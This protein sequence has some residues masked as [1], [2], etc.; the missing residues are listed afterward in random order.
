MPSVSAKNRQS[1]FPFSSTRATCSYH[2]GSRKSLSLSGWRHMPWWW[3]VGPVLRKATR[4]IF[5][6]ALIDLGVCQRNALGTDDEVDLDRAAEGQTRDADGGARRQAAGREVARVFRVH[7]R[8]VAEVH[9]VHAHHHRAA[10]ARARAGE[11][12]LE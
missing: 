1:N 12:G 3:Q 8:V 7:L 4:C 10:E 2:A 5:R 9:E 6:G 11:H